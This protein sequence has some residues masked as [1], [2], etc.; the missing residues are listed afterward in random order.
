MRVKNRLAIPFL[1]DTCICINNSW[2]LFRSGGFA[3]ILKSI[4][5]PHRI[6]Y[7]LKKLFPTN[8]SVPL[9]P[10]ENRIINNVSKVSIE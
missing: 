7:A 9:S 10:Y 6:S 2:L 8:H 3:G 5:E 4:I 1:D